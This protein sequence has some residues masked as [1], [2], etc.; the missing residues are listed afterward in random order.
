MLFFQVGEV[1]Q[2]AAVG[3]SRRSIQALLAVRPDKAN[4][5]VQGEIKS[6]A[7]ETVTVGQEILVRPGEKIPL[8]GVILEGKSQVETSALTGESVPRSVTVG[9]GV[10]A[11]MVNQSGGLTVQ[12]T[13]PFVESSIARILELVENARSKKADTEKFITRFAR[14]Y[15]PP[16]PK[17]SFLEK[18]MLN[19]LTKVL[20][21]SLLKELKS[22][23]STNSTNN[24]SSVV[25]IIT[26]VGNHDDT[27]SNGKIIRNGILIKSFHVN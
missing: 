15:F 17:M 11:G 7:P 9:D 22:K 25:N 2:G 20:V 13:K 1:I 23:S 26:R 27:W 19:N 10:L 24:Q 3:R 4:L 18:L 14:Y 5:K 16:L 21:E 12:V 8:D 6:V